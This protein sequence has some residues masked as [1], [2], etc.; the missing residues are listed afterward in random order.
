MEELEK[1]VLEMN[2][3]NSLNTL[4]LLEFIDDIERLGL[5]YRFQNTIR[6]ALRK[7]ASTNGNNIG[8]QEKEDSLH[9]VSLKFRLLRQHGYNVLQ[10]TSMLLCKTPRF[11]V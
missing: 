10:G 11:S 9:A 1:K 5:G 4:Q 3:V 7:I 6:E 8:D 2:F